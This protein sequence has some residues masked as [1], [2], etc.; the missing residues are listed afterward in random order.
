MYIDMFTE[1]QCLIKYE[2]FQVLLDSVKFLINMFCLSFNLEKLVRTFLL[3]NLVKGL[4]KRS[5]VASY[6][7]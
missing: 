2:W 1:V 7:Y 4:K 6:A 3:N 5:K